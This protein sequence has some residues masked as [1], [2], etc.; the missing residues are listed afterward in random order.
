MIATDVG[1]IPEI[2]G[3]YRDR[4][5]PPNDPADLQAR[6]EATLAMPEAQRKAEAA[7]LAAYVA[8]RFSIQ[9]MVN[10]VMTGYAEALARRPWP[11]SRAAAVAS[12]N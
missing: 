9:T 8:E 10:S 7:D 1:G 4:L 6:I 2:F 5:G 3:P 11:L 12:H